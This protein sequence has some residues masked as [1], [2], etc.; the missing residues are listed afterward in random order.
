MSGEQLQKVASYKTTQEQAEAIDLQFYG[1]VLRME[2]ATIIILTTKP[3]RAEE[4][5]LVNS[6]D[7][8]HPGPRSVVPKIQ[9]SLKH[10]YVNTQSTHTTIYTST[11]ATLPS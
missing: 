6:M 10:L 3:A 7:E 9:P 4:N 8:R 11:P 1:Q 5:A 2:S